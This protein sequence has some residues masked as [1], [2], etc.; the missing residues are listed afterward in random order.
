MFNI[1][2][3]M[4][5]SDHDDLQSTPF[6]V[7]KI[8]SSLANERRLLILSKLMQWREAHLDA[9]AQAFGVTPAALAPHLV[10]LVEDRIL[11]ERQDE[12]VVWYRIADSRIEQLISEL[13]TMICEDR[14]PEERQDP[15]GLTALRISRPE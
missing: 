8:L 5:K 12:W 14:R 9:L 11:S 7:A 2:G 10:G 15:A 4:N 3:A 1:V 6:E 13:C